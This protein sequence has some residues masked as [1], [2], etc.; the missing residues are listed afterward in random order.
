M[1]PAVGFIRQRTEAFAG[2]KWAS[3]APTLLNFGIARMAGEMS[4]DLPF[5]YRSFKSRELALNWLAMP[6]PLRK[7]HVIDRAG[8]EC[9]SLWQ[10]D[11]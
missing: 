3:Y 9:S 5:E 4:A 10:V 6:L 8:R 1:L 2:M 7:I 11:G